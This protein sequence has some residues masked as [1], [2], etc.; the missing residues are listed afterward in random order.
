MRQKYELGG[1]YAIVLWADEYGFIN[2]SHASKV[3]YDAW[4]SDIEENEQNTI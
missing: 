4:V 3:D 1:V 2:S